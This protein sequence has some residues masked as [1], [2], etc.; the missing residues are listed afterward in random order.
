MTGT[1]NII[2]KTAASTHHNRQRWQIIMVQPGRAP[3]DQRSSRSGIQRVKDP[4]DRCIEIGPEEQLRRWGVAR[5]PFSC[6][7]C[8]SPV[9]LRPLVAAAT[10]YSRPLSHL[11]KDGHTSA[12]H[13]Q[14]NMVPLWE[15]I[16]RRG[17]NG[18]DQTAEVRNLPVQMLFRQML[19]FHFTIW[20]KDITVWKSKE[21]NPSKLNVMRGKWLNITILPVTHITEIN[22]FSKLKVLINFHKYSSVGSEQL[23]SNKCK[24]TITR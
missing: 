11:S 3:T 22:H 15:L 23:H 2:R 14:D 20:D 12:T 9:K 7:S 17:T 24:T 6:T 19:N 13:K 10:R 1:E 4:G 16:P 21:Q 18:A 5:F 8:L